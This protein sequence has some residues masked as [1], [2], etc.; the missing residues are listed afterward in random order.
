MI[1]KESKLYLQS[2]FHGFVV[3]L[4]VHKQMKITK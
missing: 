4:G 1:L 2:S 3:Q